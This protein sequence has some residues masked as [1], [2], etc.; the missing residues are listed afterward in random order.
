MT[1][2]EVRSHLRSF[3]N[4]RDTGIR[5]SRLLPPTVPSLL[6]N[7]KVYFDVLAKIIYTVC[8]CSLDE[9]TKSRCRL[10][11]LLWRGARWP[12]PRCSSGWTGAQYYMTWLIV[13]PATGWVVKPP[14]LFHEHTSNALT[15]GYLKIIQLQFCAVNATWHTFKYV[16]CA[17]EC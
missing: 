11:P 3:S 8:R 15:I 17:L 12:A 16:Y 2:C 5:E 10:S 14:F 9:T 6:K 4:M 1:I 13:W 7:F